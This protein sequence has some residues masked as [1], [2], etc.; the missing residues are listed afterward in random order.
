MLRKFPGS[1][2][3]G[4]A[5]AHTSLDRNL[6]PASGN[7]LPLPPSAEIR[8]PES[9]TQQ[10]WS[11]D[12]ARMA[13]REKQGNGRVRPSAQRGNR[14]L[15]WPPG[16]QDAP[17]SR[18][19]SMVKFTRPLPAPR[20]DWLAGGWGCGWGGGAGVGGTS[21]QG[22]PLCSCSAQPVIGFEQDFPLLSSPSEETSRQEAAPSPSVLSQT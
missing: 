10:V 2:R 20:K 12:G 9:Y 11:Q 7:I 17:P 19:W 14:H 22:P 5:S 4:R 3:Q 15:P 6:C 8:I 13:K 1:E 18:V 21:F 16:W